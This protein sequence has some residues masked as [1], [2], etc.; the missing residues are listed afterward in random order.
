MYRKIMIFIFITTVCSG[1][2][3]QEKKV[4]ENVLPPVE[5]QVSGFRVSHRSGRGQ[6]GVRWE[7]EGSSAKFIAGNIV[8]LDTIIAT[9]Y[10]EEGFVKVVADEGKIDRNTNNLELRKNVKAHTSD[11]VNL[12]TDSLNWIEESKTIT[13]KDVVSVEKENIKAIGKGAIAEVSLKQVQL[14][15]DVKLEVKSGA[16]EEQGQPAL[17]P[18]IITCTG[19]LD[20]D[21][22]KSIA[23]FNENVHV[24]D[25]RGELFADTV[26]V[27]FDPQNRKILKIIAK[28][29]VRLKEGEN[30]LFG[31][32]GIYDTDTGKITITGEKQRPKL[33]FY[34]GE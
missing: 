19:P 34:P 18:T 26:E 21:F 28:G 4:Q 12:Y 31:D 22:Q 17:Q 27:F 2:K 1:C 24:I 14:K 10:S 32:K 29:N 6:Q 15:E 25:H 3:V 5:Q 33:I 30:E 23:V 7:L 8:L 20:V 9:A 11:G 16:Q 13:T